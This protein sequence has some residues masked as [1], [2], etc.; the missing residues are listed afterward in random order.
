MGILGQVI[1]GGGKGFGNLDL[2]VDGLLEN[3]FRKQ[4]TRLLATIMASEGAGP[5]G[6]SVAEDVWDK[7]L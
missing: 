4:S 7:I 6:S 5:M 1:V 3:M 2:V